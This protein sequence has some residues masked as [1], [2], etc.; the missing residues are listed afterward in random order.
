[1]YIDAR[2]LP[3]QT[4]I[5]GDLCIVGTGPA[6][7]SIA[8][9]WNN[10]PFKVILLEGGGLE[11]DDKVQDLYTARNTGQPYFPLRSTQLHYL[12][13]A[14]NHWGG[15]CAPFDPQDF[16]KR[17]WVPYSGWPIKKAD[18]DPFYERAWSV[19]DLEAPNFDVPYWVKQDPVR[20]SMFPENP[21]LWNK[22]WQFSFTR[23]GL[24]YLP[25]VKESKN[26]HLY[27]YAN[28]TEINANKDV[29]EIES[30][31][32]KNLAGKTHTVKAKRFV[33]ACGAIQNA[34]ILLANNHQAPKGLGNDNDIVG[35][36]FMDHLEMTSANLYL[37]ADDPLKLYR[38]DWGK[39]RMRCELA[40][41][42]EMQAR[43]NILNGTSSLKPIREAGLDAPTIKSWSNEDPRKN[44]QLLASKDRLYKGARALDSVMGISKYSM[45]TRMEQAPNPNSRVTLDTETDALGMPRVVLHW[46]FTSLERRSMR[47]IYEIM[48]RQLGALGS[49]RVQMMDYL[50]D[51]DDAAWPDF[52]SG[53]WH[54]MGTTRMSDD[55]H[56]GVVDA[57]CKV[58]G[59]ANLFIGGSS[60]YATAGSPNPT[61]TIVALSLRL[62]DH[63]KKLA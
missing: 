58:H 12:G 51:P 33:L 6:G 4:L 8:Q 25:A 52:T 13:G 17:S 16:E 36:F 21:I 27:T 7:M 20:K 22:V 57:N 45:F 50:E 38:H 9:E 61:F 60:C 23:F 55:P 3:D 56:T 31:T 54:H 1:M 14:S 24:K 62:S 18:L 34:R 48:G 19:V 63:L 43:H 53:G 10:T 46:E 32:V 5:E 30:L 49:A 39:T 2:N 26:I 59:I 15:Y 40:I 11:Y 37:P 41:S 35:R 28:L 42:Y 44:M 47:T 29:S